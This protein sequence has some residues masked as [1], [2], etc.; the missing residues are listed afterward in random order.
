MWPMPI[1]P[2]GMELI[3][4]ATELA[5]AVAPASA[6]I[7]EH[8][9]RSP[10]FTSRRFHDPLQTRSRPKLDALITFAWSRGIC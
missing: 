2:S 3:A 8:R 6:A 5:E 9:R 1:A 4:E 7:E 10:Q